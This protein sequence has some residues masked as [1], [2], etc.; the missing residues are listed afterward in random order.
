ME[1]STTHSG[2]PKVK[3]ISKFR[4]V[5][6]VL[7]LLFLY[8]VSFWL[9]KSR[10][11]QEPLPQPIASGADLT[12]KN[13]FSTLPNSYSDIKPEPDPIPEEIIVD[14]PPIQE[15]PMIENPVDEMEEKAR[16]SSIAFKLNKPE[17]LSSISDKS[18]L[19]F[20]L[21][22]ELTPSPD[23]VHH[24]LLTGTIISAVLV[25]EINSD[26]A[27]NITAQI[28]SHVYDSV[29]GTRLLIPQGSRLFGTYDSE[30]L[31][32]Q[33]HLK[34]AW[35][36]L[37]F[38]NGSTLHLGDKGQAGISLSGES[39]IADQVDHHYGKL[40]TAVLFS[41]ILSAGTSTVEAKDTN[42]VDLGNEIAVD[43]SQ[44]VNRTSQSIIDRQFRVKSTIKIR[45][46]FRFKV[47]LAQDIIL[48][49]YEEQKISALRFSYD[50]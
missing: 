30:I 44:D 6:F 39:A 33:D 12:A 48:P 28:S 21:N 3:R 26:I 32:N 45:A 8:A 16:Q 22:H 46:G 15:E 41:T 13:L 24:R 40:I 42:Q 2:L 37:M 9:S 20:S 1:K 14:L 11:T 18:A 10:T 29:S 36:R 38:P 23:D 17:G 34:I 50:Q 35:Y 49:P 5:I 4:V 43:L 7:G 19:S 27:G 47:M 25:T 31:Y